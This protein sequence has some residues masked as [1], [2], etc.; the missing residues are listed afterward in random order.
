MY[1]SMQAKVEPVEL[2]LLDGEHS[3]CALI[4]L[5]ISVKQ[6]ALGV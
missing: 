1:V 5:K 6:G 3:R 2:K 4:N